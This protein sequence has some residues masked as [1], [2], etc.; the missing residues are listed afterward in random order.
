MGRNLAS[1]VTDSAEREPAA[2]AEL[3]EGEAAALAELLD[4]H[5]PD[6]EL[7]ATEEGDTA[8]ILY[9]SGTTGKPKGAE[10]THFNRH[11]NAQIA[12]ETTCEVKRGDI[13]LGAL[14]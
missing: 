1:T 13:A 7:A 14:P 6:T 2:D 11:R 5:E 3:H 8:V 9:T 4:G 12:S 10:L